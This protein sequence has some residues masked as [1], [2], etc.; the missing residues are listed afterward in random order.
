MRHV[1]LCYLEFRSAQ[2][3]DLFSTGRFLL[4]ESTACLVR[5]PLASLCKEQT[6][7]LFLRLTHSFC[8]I[9]TV[10]LVL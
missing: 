5:H 4:G 2:V 9:T 1:R 10:M 6:G 7:F 3:R 8:K